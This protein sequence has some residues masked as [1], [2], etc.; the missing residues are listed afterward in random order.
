MFNLAKE[1]NHS[2]QK[3]ELGVNLK[4]LTV[5]TLLMTYLKNL[6]RFMYYFSSL[7]KNC[8]IHPE[9]NWNQVQSRGFHIS[10][11]WSRQATLKQTICKK[12][13]KG[14]NSWNIF[15]HLGYSVFTSLAAILSLLS[16][17]SST[18]IFQKDYLDN[19]FTR[20]VKFLTTDGL[21]YRDHR[22]W[23]NLSCFSLDSLRRWW[24]HG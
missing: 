2:F 13:Q 1:E 14:S 9:L 5:F 23:V 10:Q 19:T 12:S 15:S 6:T 7:I 18:K 3:K 8:E 4:S 24:R 17:F 16:V 21:T 11:R 22:L 20:D